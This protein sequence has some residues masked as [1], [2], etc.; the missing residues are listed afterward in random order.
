MIITAKDSKSQ[1]T[2]TYHELL[3]SYFKLFFIHSVIS[4]CKTTI[5]L[6]E[7]FVAL[8]DNLYLCTE[9]DEWWGL[10]KPFFVLNSE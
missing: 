1:H 4:F 5:F 10:I 6:I 3:V 7:Y 8:V 2:V 9:T